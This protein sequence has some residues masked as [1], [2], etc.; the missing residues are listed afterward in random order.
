MDDEEARLTDQLFEHLQK[1]HGY[2]FGPDDA[3]TADERYVLDRLHWDLHKRSDYG[4]IGR[5]SVAS[6]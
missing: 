2:E 3:V 4:P 6:L 5:H 1:D